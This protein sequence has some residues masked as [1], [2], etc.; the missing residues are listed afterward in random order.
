[1]KLSSENT[2]DQILALGLIALGV[3]FRI[4]PHP[5]NFTPVMAI[6]LF[7][8]VVLPPAL[9]LTVP[10]LVMM[11]SDLVIGLHSLFW[12]VWAT[13]IAIVL[14]GVWVRNNAGAWKTLAAALSGSVIF[15]VVS[16]LGVF[17][18]DNMYPK[19][20]QG[21]VQCF[22]MALPFFRNT[23]AGDLFY[24]FAFFALFLAAKWMRQP[25]K[26]S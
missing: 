4:A 26:I 11:A 1:M 23:L 16:N 9:A 13:F 19:N 24:T 2:T 7:S 25:K 18:V 3:L 12:L 22:T 8:G 5:D 21:L 17:F 10:L 14:L 15:F 20:W 6:A